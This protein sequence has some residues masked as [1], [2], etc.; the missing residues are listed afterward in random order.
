MSYSTCVC[1]DLLIILGHLGPA[2]STTEMLH[3][4]GEITQVPSVVAAI[5][6]VPSV[7]D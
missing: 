1:I 2:T 7:R 3:S 5:V 4:D 6:A